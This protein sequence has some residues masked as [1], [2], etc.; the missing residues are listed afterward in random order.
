MNTHVDGILTFDNHTITDS[1]PVINRVSIDINTN[2]DEPEYIWA[3]LTRWV[4]EKQITLKFNC[5]EQEAFILE[6][7]DTE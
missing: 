6:L 1:I 5:T 7:I 2:A 3:C 4:Q